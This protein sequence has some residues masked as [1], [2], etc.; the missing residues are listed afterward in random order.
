M[1][2]DTFSC[3][4]EYAATLEKLKAREQETVKAQ[5]AAVAMEAK[6]LQQRDLCLGLIASS[7][8]QVCVLSE[9]HCV[10]GKRNCFHSNWHS[11][12]PL[13]SYV[14]INMMSSTSFFFSPMVS[15]VIV[16]WRLFLFFFVF[17]GLFCTFVVEIIMFST[18]F[19]VFV[20]IFSI[21][22]R[23]CSCKVVSR[24][25]FLSIARCWGPFSFC[26]CRTRMTTILYIW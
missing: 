25:N 13:T 9:A 8:S 22:T 3:T 18:L 7:K 20:C 1:Y 24:D 2:I 23:S 10:P 14:F 4:T 26:V 21:V 16:E 5:S 17:F 12:K 6:A 15:S 19:C 11:T